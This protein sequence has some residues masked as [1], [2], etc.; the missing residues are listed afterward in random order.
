M[1]SAS[2]L[3]LTERQAVILT[4][5]FYMVTA[6]VMVSCNKWALNT[7]ELPWLLLWCQML[8][9]VLLLRVTNYTG[10]LRMPKIETHVAQALIPLIAI[11][12]LG[13]GVNTLCLVYVDTSFYQI[14]RGLVLP[15]TVIFAYVLLGQPSAQLVLVSCFIVF[16]GFYT[17]VTTEINV[18]HIGVF[19][20]II[21]SVTTSL[22]A[23]VIKRSLGSVNNSSIDLVYYNNVLSLL[24]TTPI[25][26]LSGEITLVA[27]RFAADG[28]QAFHSFLFAAFITGIFGFLV[29]LAGFMQI[30][31]TSPTT[32]MISGAVRGV[33]QTLLGY[34][35]F[36]DIITSGRLIGIVLI[37]SGGALYTWAKDQEM[38]ANIKP[39]YIPMTQQDVDGDD[40][41]HRDKVGKA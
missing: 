24:A 9:A 26:F 17:G 8:I 37:L 21:S 16:C 11:N 19:F 18:S 13:L 30:S 35:A 23:I 34:F 6:L 1:P 5:G 14:A 25:V 27:E 3:G 36:G 40:G 22:H 20:G 39:T 2:S 7:I 29:N 15:F 41:D 10:V 4:V 28:F 31:K 12:V 38:R 33:L 32:H